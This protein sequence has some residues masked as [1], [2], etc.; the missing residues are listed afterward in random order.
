[1]PHEL[2]PVL[3]ARLNQNVKHDGIGKVVIRGDLCPFCRQMMNERLQKHDGDWHQ[4]M[5]EMKVYRLI[6]SEQDRV[7]IGT[8]QPKDGE[9]Q[10]ST[11]QTGDINYRKN[12]EIGADPA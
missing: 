11:E 6:L 7:G 4:V 10:D 12:A 5:E 9:D 1:V 3:L 2:R 8:F